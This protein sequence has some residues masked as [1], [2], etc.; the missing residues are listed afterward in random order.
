MTRMHLAR[1]LLAIAGGFTI[2]SGTT[3]AAPKIY[4]YETAPSATITN[5]TSSANCTSGT[6]A[7]NTTF[8]VSESFTVQSIA[9]GLN[10]SHTARGDIRGVL[11]A[12]GGTSFTFMA[13]DTSVN[14]DHY[15]I[16]VANGFGTSEVASTALN[17]GDIDPI[18]EPYYLR[19]VQNTGMDFYTGNAN[20]TWTLR[21][22][23]RDSG[24][25]VGTLNRAKLILTENASVNQ[26]T[27]SGRV[28]Y[29][30]GDNGNN[31]NFTS[32]TVGGITITET[33]ADSLGGA[34]I[35]GNLV[36]TT[37]TTGNHPGYYQFFVD[38][39]DNSGTDI[40]TV[41]QMTEFT[42][43]T[44]VN[45]LTFSITDNDWAND[46]FEDYTTVVGYD[47]NGNTVPWE[48]TGGG[49]TQRAGDVVEGDGASSDTQTLGNMD[50]EFA[51]SVKRVLIDYLVG[52][53]FDTDD[54][55]DDQKTGITDLTFCGFDFGD[56]PTSYNVNLTGNGARHVLRNRLVR[57]GATVPDGETDGAGDTN[58]N[59]DGGDEDGVA[60]WPTYVTAGTACTG[61]TTGANEYCVNVNVT[62]TSGSPANVAGWIDFNGDGDFNDT[63]ER[64]LPR[65]RNTGGVAGADDTTWTT[66]NVPT[67]TSGATRVL[68]WSGFGV[69]VNS[70]TATFARIRLTTNATA[71]FFTDTT[72]QPNG[73]AEDG[74]VEDYRLPA[75]TL[76]VSLARVR[77][78][79][80]P[81]GLHIEF[82]TLAEAG[83]VGFEIRDVN[84]GRALSLPIPAAEHG[85]M[86]G[87]YEVHLAAGTLESFYIDD[88]ALD[89]S[90]KTHGPYDV[91]KSYGTD[92][93]DTDRIDWT[94]VGKTMPTKTFK[95]GAL[96][97]LLGVKDDGI[98]RIT[99]DAL[100][101]GGLSLGSGVASSAL[102]LKDYG[103]RVPLFVDDAGDGEFG[104]GDA[105]EF[106]GKRTINR[107]SNTNW[108]TLSMDG[109]ARNVSDMPVVGS[110]LPKV[111]D[112][113]YTQEADRRFNL[114]IEGTS[115]WVD[116]QIL[117]YDKAVSIARTFTLPAMAPLTP[118]RVDVAVVGGTDLTTPGPDHSIAVAVNG[119]NRTTHT[120]DGAI[121]QSVG[122]DIP[123]G[124]LP[125]T[126]EMSLEVSADLG[127]PFDLVHYDRF[128]VHYK[129]YTHVVDGRFDAAFEAGSGFA[130]TGVSTS[131][132]L[133][134]TGEQGAWRM[135][136]S[137][138]QTGLVGNP[139][140]G[141]VLSWTAAGIDR[142]STPVIASVTAPADLPDADFL[143][144][145]HPSLRDA[146]TDYVALQRSRG[147]TV[148]VVDT[149]A[150][151]A[152]HGD[153]EASAQA[154]S[155]YIGAM[156]MIAPLK[157]V[158]LVG[159]DTYD[160]RNYLGIGSVSF[161]PTHYEKTSLFIAQTPSDAKHVDVDDDGVPDIAIG[162][163]PARTQEELLGMTR[164][165][166]LL[167]NRTID[168]ALFVSGKDDSGTKR[169]GGLSLDFSTGLPERTQTNL[170]QMDDVGRD[171]TREAILAG[172]NSG[173]PL[174]SYTGHTAPS[175]WDFNGLLFSQDA[176]SM[177]NGGSPTLVTQWGCWNSYFVDPYAQGLSHQLMVAQ[178]GAGT[179]YGATTLTED[180]SHTLLG[181]LF[182]E[183]IG[184]GAR[185]VGEAELTAKRRLAELRP[186][187]RDAQL[188]MQIL[189]DPAMPIRLP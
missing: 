182:F 89:G 155:A 151:Y 67:G 59:L 107:Y 143:V 20:G 136:L 167:G 106:I 125:G 161:V 114:S 129:R 77:S 183:A 37:A 51:G 47:D 172:F 173:I 60:S 115:P 103:A 133:W 38:V 109:S 1:I 63:G 41:G 71:S 25:T 185:T 3:F 123:E 46:D 73:L 27:C 36:T 31:A 44:A 92:Q 169:F 120:F 142:M 74:E 68:V 80:S 108:L 19:L 122:I 22:C 14:T 158:T 146:T 96:K 189:G 48:Y 76:P 56:A 181:Q 88:I 145:T 162:R 9:I 81:D 148:A 119:K 18:A 11:T 43:S 100:K 49:S 32:A 140:A 102:M 135:P 23:D 138:G 97:L 50:V 187:I 17:D 86:G 188:G 112:A 98:Q 131:G 83:N 152:R 79:Q 40:E 156:H 168:K 130:L 52:D 64:S 26:S 121:P 7:L 35:A 55:P 91:G 78:S 171:G 159:A 29:N 105:I 164:K 30:W 34:G 6:G 90:R 21:L 178:G 118:V 176:A 62:N 66:G 12:P 160:Y 134:A 154:I 141:A 75:G 82:G 116:D 101:R 175:L 165:I 10:I 170:V 8:S 39:V 93:L 186:D 174:I 65:I 110:A 15:D 69:P 184:A 163:L 16:L 144:I 53:D 111:V 128:D 58:A 94:A 127:L 137:A 45:D 104:P 147:Y 99:F 87:D 42:F 84:D 95:A 2:A 13:E 117:A 57:L 150:I 72:P 139:A 153:Y 179:I 149:D 126:Q 28:A 5:V 33:R 113:V 54:F 166:I 61:Y 124:L 132:S 70:S 180:S 157:Y 4:R 24:S 177:T 85:V